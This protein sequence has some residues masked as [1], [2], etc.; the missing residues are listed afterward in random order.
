MIY[1]KDMFEYCIVMLVVNFF[2]KNIVHF[3]S[4]STKKLYLKYI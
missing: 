2:V 3:K 4:L 1:A